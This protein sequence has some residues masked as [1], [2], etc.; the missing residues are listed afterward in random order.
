MIMNI[1]MIYMVKMKKK[2]KETMKTFPA[3]ST[4]LL[5]LG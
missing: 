5:P 2:K 1:K 4:L 3:S